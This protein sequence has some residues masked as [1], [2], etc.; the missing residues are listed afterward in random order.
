MVRIAGTATFWLAGK[1]AIRI[2]KPHDHVRFGVVLP[3]MVPTGVHQ[4][5]EPRMDGRN[6]LRIGSAQPR[7]DLGVGWRDGTDENVP[8]DSRTVRLRL[9]DQK[10]AP[11]VCTTRH[12]TWV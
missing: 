8:K 4:V 5:P 11:G 9:L 7:Y 3:R 6:L 1:L 2:G 12:R 10:D